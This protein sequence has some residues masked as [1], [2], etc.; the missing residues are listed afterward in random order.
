MCL[1]ACLQRLRSP[2]TAGC[3]AARIRSEESHRYRDVWWLIGRSR[4]MDRRTPMSH[5]DADSTGSALNVLDNYMVREHVGAASA[6]VGWMFGAVVD[7]C[8]VMADVAL[9]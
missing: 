7:A 5:H 9:R 2:A 4:P 8:S 6:G 3:E 1:R